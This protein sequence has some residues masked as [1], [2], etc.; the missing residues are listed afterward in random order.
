[1]FL[2]HSRQ[3]LQEFV[4]D[5]RRVDA[6]LRLRRSQF[7]GGGGGEKAVGVEH[8]P[9]PGMQLEW[10]G[11]MLTASSEQEVTEAAATFALCKMAQ[12][13]IG[14]NLVIKEVIHVI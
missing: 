12:F 8:R 7:V 1:M 13:L 14:I 2:R 4:Q 5:Q 10:G 11:G 6:V 9:S 3:L